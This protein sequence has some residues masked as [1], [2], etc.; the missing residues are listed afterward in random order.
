MKNRYFLSLL[1]VLSIILTLAAF[2]QQSKTV[3]PETELLKKHVSYLA[4]DELEGRRPGT[5]GADKAADYLAEQFHRLKLGCAD[6]DFKCRHD[7]KRRS[8]YLKEFPLIAD[9]QLARKNAMSFPLGDKDSAVAL[10][11]DWAPLG[12]SANG[13][14]QARLV[15]AGHGIT[16]AELKHDDYANV[17]AKGRIAVVFAGS[18][19]GDNPHGQ[20]GRFADV[21]LKAIAA[22]DHGAA[23]L[24]V[25]AGDE[26]FGNERLAKLSYDQTAGEAAIPVAVISRQTAAKIFGLADA[27][28][29]NA[30]EKSKEKWQEAAQKIQNVT[31]NLS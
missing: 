6:S 24:V 27:A 23:A 28:Q 14:R 25:I 18:P 29:F 5:A 19:D 20:F 12:F 31:F 4:S 22:N 3:A 26:K 2:V 17:D 9:V 1:V 13:D 15:F 11:D 30:L 10:R 7:G 8:G 21:R 16:A